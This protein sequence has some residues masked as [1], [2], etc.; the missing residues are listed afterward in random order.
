[1]HAARADTFPTA[2]LEALASGVPVIAS[3]VGGIPEQ[4]H[5]E[6]A[7]GSGATEPTGVLVPPGDPVALA[8][9]IGDLL[10]DDGRRHRLG[11]AAARD[12]RDRFDAQRQTS[13]YVDWAEEIVAESAHSGPRDSG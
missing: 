6:G 10:A 2:V 8:T 3:A 9:A 4:I 13:V 12:A 7:T 11:A 1:V 5:S